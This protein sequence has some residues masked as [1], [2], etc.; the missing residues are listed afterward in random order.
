MFQKES[1]R[2]NVINSPFEGCQHAHN[3]LKPII[4]HNKYRMHT[5][6]H[7]SAVQ[8]WSTFPHRYLITIAYHF[9][10]P[11][12]GQFISFDARCL[13]QHVSVHV[14]PHVS[15]RCV[16]APWCWTPS[17]TNKNRENFHINLCISFDGVW[18][19]FS[20]FRM[21][22]VILYRSRWLSLIDE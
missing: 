12:N 11:S 15:R 13:S 22:L 14:R 18:H 17:T 16:Y 20:P 6:S 4:A 9:S 7:R 3:E 8:Q 21:S 19:G 5:I 2:R 1:Q 10:T